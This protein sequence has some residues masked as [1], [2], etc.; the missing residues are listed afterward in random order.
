VRWPI[1]DAASYKPFELRPGAIVLGL[2]RPLI[3]GET[4]VAVVQ[5]SDVPALLLQRV[6]RIRVKAGFVGDWLFLLLAGN[7]FAEYLAPIFTGISVPHLS[8]E[9]IK[10]FRFALPDTTKQLAVVR[11][12]AA[13]TAGIDK[14]RARAASE[15]ELLREYRRRL[16]ADVVTGKLDVREAAAR[17]PEEVEEAEPVD[18]CEVGLDTLD[19]EEEVEALPAEAEA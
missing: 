13:Q 6:A 12:I 17:L 16:I 15:I 10:S 1:N 3:G 8:P 2:D 19:A 11:W 9:Q 14:A 4:R 18:E 5:E 7:S